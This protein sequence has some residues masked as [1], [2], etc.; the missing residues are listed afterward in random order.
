MKVSK[1]FITPLAGYLYNILSLLPMSKT[2]KVKFDIHEHKLT[3]FY[4][5]LLR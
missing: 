1:H 2:P 4:L 3:E 5:A